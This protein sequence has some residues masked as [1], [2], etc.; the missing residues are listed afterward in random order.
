MVF[1]TNLVSSNIVLFLIEPPHFV[2][3]MKDLCI[4]E[5]KKLRLEC[6]FTGTPKISAT[7]Y[8]DSRPLPSSDKYSMKVTPSMCVLESLQES[9]KE[10]AGQYSCEIRSSCGTDICYA[11]VT[12]LE[13]QREKAK[14]IPHDRSL[15]ARGDGRDDNRQATHHKQ[16]T[17]ST[18]TTT[19]HRGLY[20]TRRTGIL[21]FL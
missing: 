6:T 10:T 8:K 17:F 18:T 1:A 21:L 14:Q 2:T 16:V 7:W 11:D 9:N 5:G 13:V 12:V 20:I 19:Y 3:K 4:P 15:D